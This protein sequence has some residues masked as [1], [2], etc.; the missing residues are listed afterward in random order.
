MMFYLLVYH[1]IKM[2]KFYKLH[3]EACILKDM[4]NNMLWP[5]SLYMIY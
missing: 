4:N 2:M 1:G 3:I 5:K